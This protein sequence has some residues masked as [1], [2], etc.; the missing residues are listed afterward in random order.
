MNN[1]SR[2]AFFRSA[3]SPSAVSPDCSRQDLRRFRIAVS[4]RRSTDFESPIRPMANLHHKLVTFPFPSA[5][6][7]PLGRGRTTHRGCRG[8][9]RS[10]VRTRFSMNNRNAAPTPGA[11]KFSEGAVTRSLS[12][13]R[14]DAVGVRSATKAKPGRTGFQPVLNPSK[15]THQLV[16]SNLRPAQQA[17]PRSIGI[18]DRLEACPTASFRPRERAGARGPSNS[19]QA[20][21]RP[22]GAS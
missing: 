10:I 9:R 12:P 15:T 8:R 3:D 7:S 5:Q 2:I 17:F 16:A 4:F 22:G 1:P 13:S 19:P 21:S 14:N 18:R 20:S 6:P 11:M